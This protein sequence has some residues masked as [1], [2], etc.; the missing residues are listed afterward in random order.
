M[1]YLCSNLGC[2][3]FIKEM[4]RLANILYILLLVCVCVCTV[5]IRVYIFM[6]LRGSMSPLSWLEKLGSPANCFECVYIYI[7]MYIYTYI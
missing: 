2:A 6:C 1:H 3:Y 7:C 4:W 5:Y